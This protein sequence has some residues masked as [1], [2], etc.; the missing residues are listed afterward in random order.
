MEQHYTLTDAEFEWQ[1]A[2]AKLDPAVFS[3]AAHLR[4]AWIHLNRYELERAIE[5]ITEQL[6][7]YTRAAGVAAKYHETVTI[8]AVYAVN[9]KA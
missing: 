9:L 4:L 1:F 5:H 7:D 2:S 8:A 6:R 3:H